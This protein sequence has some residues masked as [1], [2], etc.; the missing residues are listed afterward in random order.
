MR[1]L[2]AEH[3]LDSVP[4]HGVEEEYQDSSQEHEEDGLQDD[5]LVGFRNQMKDESGR[6]KQR[7]MQGIMSGKR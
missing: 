2:C 7:Q 5:P 4:R 6:L 1:G 3:P